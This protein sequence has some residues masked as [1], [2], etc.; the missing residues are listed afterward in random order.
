MT[1]RLT[2]I[3]NYNVSSLARSTPSTRDRDSFSII[4]I[5]FVLSITYI[6]GS[7]YLS[8]PASARACSRCALYCW[9]RWVSMSIFPKRIIQLSSA[10]ASYSL[11][12]AAFAAR[13]SGRPFVLAF[14]A[15]DSS[16]LSISVSREISRVYTIYT[17]CCMQPRYNIQIF[18]R[19]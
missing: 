17:Y 10:P 15:V 4:C 6:A 16:F 7:H 11:R 19:V 1:I 9:C 8:T 2:R 3:W 13:P 12:S 18:L 14:A 5:P